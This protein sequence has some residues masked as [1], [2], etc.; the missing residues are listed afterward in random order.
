MILSS[1]VALQNTDFAQMVFEKDPSLDLKGKYGRELLFKA[2]EN[3]RRNTHVVELLL[4][5]GASPNLKG[6]DGTRRLL[7][8]AEGIDKEW[9][10]QKL[11]FYLNT[12]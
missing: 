8:K 11:D 5:K 9:L 7:A 10:A 6:Y 12:A 3:G 4:E 2:V 1:A